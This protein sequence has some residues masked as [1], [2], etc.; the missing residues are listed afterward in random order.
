M[1][2]TMGWS[3]DGRGHISQVSCECLNAH[4]EDPVPLCKRVRLKHKARLICAGKAQQGLRDVGGERRASHRSVKAER[5]RK[6]RYH[7]WSV[8]LLCTYGHCLRPPYG[9]GTFTYHRHPGLDVSRGEAGRSDKRLPS[10]PAWFGPLT[11]QRV[12]DKCPPTD[13]SA[14]T[15]AHSSMNHLNKAFYWAPSLSQLTIHS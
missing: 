2:F 10:H 4:S 8:L 1:S 6:K 3:M 9:K 11:L 14:K 5:K 7:E 12:H 13:S 15:P